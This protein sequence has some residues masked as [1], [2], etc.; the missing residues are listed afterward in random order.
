MLE[1]LIIK[2]FQK[3]E[4]LKIDFDPGV[5]CL[6]GP[7]DIGKSAIVRALKWLATNRPGGEAFIRD[8]SAN[9]SVKLVV[10]GRTI[11][12]SRGKEGNRYVLDGQELVAFGSEVPPDVTALLNISDITFQNQIDLPFWF[13]NTPGEV[14]R[15]L[16]QIVDLGSIDTTLAHLNSSLRTTTVEVG[17]LESRLAAA[18]EERKALRPAKAMHKDLTAVED[19]ELRHNAAVNTFDLARSLCE[20]ARRYGSE[21]KRA[22]ER[23]KRGL[24]VVLL[25]EEWVGL[26]RKWAGLDGLVKKARQLGPTAKHKAPDFTGL[27]KAVEGVLVA[28]SKATALWNMIDTAQRLF[29]D[30]KST[31]NSDSQSQKAL[32]KALGDRCPICLSPLQKSSPSV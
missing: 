27:D 17:L 7:S 2:N 15:S 3:H 20:K 24:A 30:L 9:T 26:G 8:G 16:N 21:A 6:I 23:S 29:D 5:N 14:S 12:R 19:L 28:E 31:K 18:Q 4:K 32:K 10:D 25:G 22:G 13:A 11:I 1:K